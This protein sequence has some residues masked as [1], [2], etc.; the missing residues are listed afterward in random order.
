LIGQA[1][2]APPVRISVNLFF[3]K[4]YVPETMPPT[5]PVPSAVIRCARP[6]IWCARARTTLRG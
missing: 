1:T 2:L 3:Q 5:V 4:V 6:P